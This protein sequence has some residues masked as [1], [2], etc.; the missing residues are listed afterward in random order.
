ALTLPGSMAVAYPPSEEYV[1]LEAGDGIYIVAEKLASTVAEKSGFPEAKTV[2]RFPGRVLENTW[3][4]HPFLPW[5]RRKILGVLADYVTMDTGTGVVHTAPSHG[6][7]DF[8]T[9]TRYKLDPT[10]EV[11]ASGVIHNGLPEYDGKKVFDANKPIVELLKI[12][13]VLL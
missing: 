8:Y 9:G 6:A 2:A 1:A 5:E 12:R 7:E 13:G 10:C 11:D 3:F 4:Y